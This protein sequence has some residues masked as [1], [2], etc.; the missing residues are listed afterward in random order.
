MGSVWTH[1]LHP[2]PQAVSRLRNR[3][4]SAVLCLIYRMFGEAAEHLLY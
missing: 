1:K 2:D 3:D 4:V